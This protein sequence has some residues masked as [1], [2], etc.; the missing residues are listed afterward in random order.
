MALAGRL[1]SRMKFL[2][3]G[4]S[5]ALGTERTAAIRREAGTYVLIMPYNNSKIL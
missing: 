1:Y 5:G 3:V 4:F 2:P